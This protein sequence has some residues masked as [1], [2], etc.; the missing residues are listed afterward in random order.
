M[1]GDTLFGGT[2]TDL[3]DSLAQYLEAAF[4]SVRTEYGL[5]PLPE[6]GQDER[7]MMFLGIGRGVVDY[8]LDHAAAF[9]I[10][11][12]GDSEPWEHDI[13]SN[14][15]VRLRDVDGDLHPS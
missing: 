12:H 15:H 4:N 14:G 5:D 10:D 6:E 2:R 8:L 11:D 9:F 1:A 7:M 13:D 3:T